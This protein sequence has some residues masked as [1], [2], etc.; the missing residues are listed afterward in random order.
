MIKMDEDVTTWA[1]SRPLS[2]ALE[3]TL[4]PQPQILCNPICEHLYNP[5]NILTKNSLFMVKQSKPALVMG[6]A[7]LVHFHKHTQ[8]FTSK[9]GFTDNFCCKLFVSSNSTNTCTSSELSRTALHLQSGVFRKTE[10]VLLLPHYLGLLGLKN[11]TF[12][13]FLNWQRKKLGKE[14]LKQVICA[15][16]S[17]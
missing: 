5:I 1:L 17:F 11:R 4:Q 9:T 6:D 16:I 8:S 12:I 7:R 3:T 15:I 2:Y 10:R 13:Y 14:K